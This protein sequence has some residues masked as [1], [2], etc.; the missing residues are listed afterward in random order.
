MSENKLIMN[1]NKLI[2]SETGMSRRKLLIGAPSALAV[3]ALATPA[4]FHGTTAHAAMAQQKFMDHRFME[5]ENT[6]FNRVANSS[7]TG[8]IARSIAKRYS[9]GYNHYG[10]WVISE[11]ILLRHKRAGV[12]HAALLINMQFTDTG[13]PV[14]GVTVQLMPANFNTRTLETA[15]ETNHP[16]AHRR[17]NLSLSQMTAKAPSA[18]APKFQGCT[19]VRNLGTAGSGGYKLDLWRQDATGGSFIIGQD[20]YHLDD[21][22]EWRFVLGKNTGSTLSTRFFAV[23][24]AI[25]AHRTANFFTVLQLAGGVAVV[26]ASI[27][28]FMAPVPIG[29][30][31]AAA[32][33]MSGLTLLGTGASTQINAH[34][35]LVREYELYQGMF[36]TSI[37]TNE[38]SGYLTAN[39]SSSYWNNEVAEILNIN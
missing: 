29:K 27:A 14:S 17:M 24:D 23:K 11:T 15:H 20:Y 28:A 6:S 26:G 36:E 5:Y 21:S 8:N 13:Y 1:D 12:W 35:K 31:A 2:T 38:K 39:D 7:P 9:R 3:A 32:G 18:P 37:R 34:N 19:K 16:S 33:V 10:R 4:F 25:I 30:A 22:K